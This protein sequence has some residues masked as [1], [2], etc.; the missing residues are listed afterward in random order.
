MAQENLRKDSKVEIEAPNKKDSNQISR[1]QFISRSLGSAGFWALT[2]SGLGTLV[3][4]S[5]KGGESEFQD[6]IEELLNEMT[7]EEK[8]N[9]LR[10]DAPAIPRLNIP[11]YNWWNECLH[12]VGR[13]GYATV[14]PQ[15]MGMA[16]TWDAP[17]FNRVAEAISDE[18][19]AKHQAFIEAGRRDIYM[20]LTFW[21][22]NINI[23]RDPR[24]GR[25]QETYGEDPFLTGTL[26]NSF[27]DGLQGDHPKYH[28]VVATSKHF[29]VYNGPEPLRHQI[30]V[31]VSDRDLH[32][33]YLP[34]FKTT[35][36]DAKVA[37]VMCAYNSFRGMPCCGSNPLLKSILRNDWNFD[38][39][40]VSDC[41]A[42]ND[43]YMEDRHGTTETEAEAAAL[44]LKSGTDLNCGNTFPYLQ[45]AYDKDLITDQD[46]NTALRRLLGARFKLGMFDD[47]EEVPYSDIPYSVVDSEEHRELARRMSRESIVLL[48]NEPAAG[49]DEPFLPLSKNIDSIAVIGPNSDNY[50]S[51]LGNYHGTPAAVS[52]PLDGIRNKVGDNTE[53]RY[54]LG[55]HFV[56][57]FPSME[58]VSS[59]YL[60]PSEGQGN[61]LY[62]QY[63]D[64]Q[65]WKGEPAM[66][67]VDSQVDFIWRD[68]TPI[69]GN[70][71]DEFS[72]VW[73][74]KIRAPKTGTYAIGLNGM[75]FIRLYF[76][77]EQKFERQMNHS[78]WYNYFEVDLEEGETYD[79]EIEF[80]SYGPD[81]QIQLVWEIPNENRL[82]E[83][84]GIAQESDVVVLCMGLSARL[85][86]EEMD[87]EVE[88]FKGGDRTKL[89]LP[90]TQMKLIKEI[91]SLGKP[92]VLVLMSGSAVAL[93]WSDQNIPA[94]LQAWYGGQAGG[95][96]LADVLFGDY[97]PAGRLPVTFYKSVDDLPEFT[98]YDMDN[99]TYKYF[100]GEGLYPFGHG[101]S[102]TNFEYGNIQ[103]SSSEISSQGSSEVTV[104]V[105]ITNSGDRD[106]EEVAQLYLSYPDGD[107]QRL[108]KELKAFKRLNIPSGETQTV[109]FELDDQS[110]ARWSEE[111][112]T[113]GVQPG[114]V[115]IRVGPS[116]SEV[117]ASET[118]I[119]S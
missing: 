52:T 76:E 73:S 107:D 10:Y 25:G 100:D 83:A 45:E 24:W 108:N 116:S 99:R 2:T 16:A 56:D 87:I 74:G 65:D 43:F 114:E 54:A 98:N 22:P 60:T 33:T 12:G 44:A 90:S 86:A 6:R 106:G 103:L 81:P 57:G 68:D 27:I 55:S 20:G 50:W 11:Q 53:I 69:N 14:F 115:N 117:A 85:E 88:G 112:G 47:P 80:Y 49:Q 51:M 29:A 71:A 36:E 66:S 19:R 28:K 5:D 15:A 18:A 72:A 8:I 3:Q 84:K 104:S 9:Q 34:M 102:Y 37:S 95:D 89:A 101:L 70:I 78:P 23:V 97:N 93:N 13:A 7:V 91:Y 48:K 113:M 17:L 119:I 109:E 58:P 46:L 21:T 38:G 63:Y 59:E 40:V 42:I 77:G 26:A 62:G 92:V 32:E 39:Y 67:R 82:E 1:R 111:Q 41:W 61:G 31:E 110:F 75:N 79:I 30:N 118:L 96:A 64:N 94:I 105:E 4:C 35:V